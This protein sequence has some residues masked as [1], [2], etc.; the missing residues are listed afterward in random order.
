MNN[1]KH[2]NRPHHHHQYS[3]RHH[4]SLFTNLRRPASSVNA[5]STTTA[6]TVIPVSDSS[7]HEKFASYA[8]IKLLIF[9]TQKTMQSSRSRAKNGAKSGKVDGE[10]VMLRKLS[11]LACRRC[12]RPTCLRTRRRFTFVSC[13]VI[14]CLHLS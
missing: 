7:E 1:F 13:H 12:C 3:C 14:K 5:S 6:T 10:A 4:L 11:F 8:A 2:I 9:C